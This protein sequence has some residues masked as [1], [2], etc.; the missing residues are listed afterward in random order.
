MSKP[1]IDKFKYELKVPFSYSNGGE[2][3]FAEY[4]TI[5]APNNKVL[6]HVTFLESVHAKGVRA[7][8]KDN[9]DTEDNTKVDEVKNKLAQQTPEEAKASR[10]QMDTLI[11]TQSGEYSKTY[12][13]L[14][15]ILCSQANG[16]A[17]CSID[18]RIAMTPVLF[19]SMSTMDSKGVLLDYYA[20]FIDTLA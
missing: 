4:L 6:D 11:L 17:T 13:A 3:A 18:D 20:N 9:D 7:M 19:D 1:Y 10:H 8:A 15:A 14:K 2:E 16:R 5:Y 12:I